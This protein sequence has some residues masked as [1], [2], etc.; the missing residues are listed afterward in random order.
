MMLLP[1]NNEPETGSRI[2][3]QRILIKLVIFFGVLYEQLIVLLF[4]DPHYKPR[5]YTDH[6]PPTFLQFLKKF[7]YRLH[8]GE[9]FLK[10]FCFILLLH[11]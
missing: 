9:F 8:K 3:S 11:R 2:P 10:K 5:H 4:L 6:K 1:Y 7:F